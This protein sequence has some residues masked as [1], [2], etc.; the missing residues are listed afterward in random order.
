MQITFE[1][2]CY[3]NN[4]MQKWEHIITSWQKEILKVHPHHGLG[5]QKFAIL[6]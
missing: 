1:K 3:K 6:T 2:M 5:Q 4:L